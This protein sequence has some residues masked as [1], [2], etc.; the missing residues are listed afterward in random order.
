[1]TTYG[2][3]V[4]DVLVALGM[5][6]DDSLWYRDNVLQNVLYAENLLVTQDLSKDTGVRGN[7]LGASFKMSWVVVPVSH[8]D[9]VSDT[10]PQRSYF[11]LPSQ[12]YNLPFDS[13][14][15]FIRYH[16][17][18]LPP[19]CPPSVAGVSFSQTTMGA[20]T[21]H[22]GSSYQNPRYDRP[23][24]VRFKDGANDRVALFGVS[25]LITK[26][27]VGLFYAPVFDEVS[28]SDTMLIDPHRLNDLKRLVLTMSVWPLGIPQE[29]LKND[30]RDIEPNQ[31][32]NPRP[33]VGVNDPIQNSF[34]E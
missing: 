4:D 7:G 27:E 34:T 32:I 24:Y 12:V 15:S 31:V 29:R 1:M 10:D 20:L 26:V 17:P 22:Y 11:D 3:F 6:Q 16:R 2:Q 9:A 25:P 33:L 19:G 18:S 8:N 30:G 14:I 23:Y 13:G 5:V 28:F 21:G